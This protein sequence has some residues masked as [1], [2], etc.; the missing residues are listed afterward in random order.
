VATV[1]WRYALI[2][3]KPPMNRAAPNLNLDRYL[4]LMHESYDNLAVE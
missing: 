2:N 4:K 1:R 3:E